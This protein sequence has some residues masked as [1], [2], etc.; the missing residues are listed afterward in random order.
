MIIALIW[1]AK[2]VRHYQV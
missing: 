1:Q 2:R